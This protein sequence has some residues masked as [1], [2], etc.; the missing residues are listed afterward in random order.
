MAGSLDNLVALVTG[1]AGT[2]GRATVRRFAREGAKVAVADLRLDDVEPLAAELGGLALELDVRSDE[3]WAVAVAALRSRFGQLDVLVNNAGIADSAG[4]EALDLE[5]WDQV[6][7]VNQ[8]GVLLGM[9]HAAPEMRRGGGGSIVNI[10]S[11]HGLVGKLS[12]D[13]SAIAY[14]ATKGAVRM[15]SKAAAMDLGGD[16]IRV[17]SV[18]PGYVD[19]PMEGAKP[20]AREHA[21]TRTPFGKLVTADDVAAGILFLASADSAMITGTEL[22]ID[23]GYTAN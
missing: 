19:A 6:L 7:A 2:I 12:P 1:G 4:V 13:G 15:M 14:S 11:I 10:S 22:T 3:S 18:H 9:R 17:N 8:T 16:G 20:G 5:I 21:V 23:G